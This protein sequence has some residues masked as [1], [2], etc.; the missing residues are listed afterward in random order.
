MVVSGIE[1]MQVQYGRLDTASNTRY[2]NANSIAGASTDSPTTL[3]SY[4]WDEVNS[5]RIW[6][7]ARNS[8]AEP[9]YTNTTSYVMGD[10]TYTVNDSFR[11]QLFTAVVQLRN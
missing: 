2:Y 6:L 9:G 10:L 7:L 8:K 4:A 3:T 1:H 5:V 11:R